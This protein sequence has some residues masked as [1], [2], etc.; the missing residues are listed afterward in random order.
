MATP[1]RGKLEVTMHVYSGRPDPTWQIDEDSV[2]ADLQFEG[3]K[4]HAKTQSQGLGYRGFSVKRIK[5]ESGIPPPKHVVTEGAMLTRTDMA[6]EDTDG[7]LPGTPSSLSIVDVPHLEQ[8]L[9]DTSN[10]IS[11]SLK[12][13]VSSCLTTGRSTVAR[14]APIVTESA[15]P[16]TVVDTAIPAPS[17]ILKEAVHGP[18]FEPSKWNDEVHVRFNNCYNYGNNKMTDTFAQPGNASN[19]PFESL[20]GAEVKRAAEA[21]GLKGEEE[22]GWNRVALVI[23]PELPDYHWYR[24]DNTGYWSHKPGQTPVLDTDNSGNK[25]SDPKGCDRGPYTEFV[26]YMWT[27][28]DKMDGAPTVT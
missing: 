19:Q 20:T 16:R 8:K 5:T 9:L 2:D 27:S 17:E 13:Y 3:L 28:P 7:R 24:L 25:I 1:L 11:E 14:M 26:G 6:T 18:S 21:D 10:V 4:L 12:K 23:W 22:S 15:A